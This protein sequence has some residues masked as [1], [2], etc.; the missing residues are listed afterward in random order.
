M[1]YQ[2]NANCDSTV[3]NS[4]VSLSYHPP[5]QLAQADHAVL[6]SAQLFSGIY[7]HFMDV[8]TW[9]VC[10]WCVSVCVGVGCV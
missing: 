9:P 2:V 8:E 6:Y 3:Y 1:T 10:T 7:G 4:P 5:P